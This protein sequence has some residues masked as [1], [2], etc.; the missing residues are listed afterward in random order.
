MISQNV[1]D[2]LDETGTFPAYSGGG[3]YCLYYMCKNREAVCAE[4]LTN[5]EGFKTIDAPEWNVYA[6]GVNWAEDEIYCAHCNK[7]IE[8]AYETDEE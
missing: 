3:G 8:C 6:A 7:L 1:L 4:C 2:L 5:E